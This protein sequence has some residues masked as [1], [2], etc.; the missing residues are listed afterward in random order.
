MRESIHGLTIKRPP[1]QTLKDEG[2]YRH[3]DHVSAII[4]IIENIGE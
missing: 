3:R 1:R 2:I 4:G